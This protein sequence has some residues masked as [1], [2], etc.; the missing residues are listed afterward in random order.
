MEFFQPIEGYEDEYLGLLHAALDAMT[1]R[2]H[3]GGLTF[4][5][6]NMLFQLKTYLGIETNPPS[7]NWIKQ[8]VT[9][10]TKDIIRY[11]KIKEERDSNR[12]G[13]NLNEFLG[14]ESYN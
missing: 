5:E 14:I 10:K 3:T 2:K 6:D 1:E 8:Q 13:A 12:N 7:F 11:N 4:K 9:P